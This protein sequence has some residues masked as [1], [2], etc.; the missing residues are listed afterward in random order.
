MD[1]H[2][3]TLHIPMEPKKALEVLNEGCMDVI[4]YGKINGTDFFCTCGVGFDA[5][6]S[7]KFAHAGKRGLLTYLEKTLQESLKYQPETYELKT[8]NGVTKYKSF[9]LI[10][11]GNASQYGNNAYIAP[12]ATLT[13]WIAGCDDSRNL[14][15]FWMCLRS[16][17]SYSIK[18]S[19]R[20]VGS[21]HS[22][23]D[24]CVFVEP[25]RVWYISTVI[26]WKRMLM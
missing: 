24:D 25:L 1:L 15:P 26:L 13:E 2:G 14:S 4:D 18:Q 5:F 17:F 9:F 21:R 12:Q 7:L 23:V 8:E 19:I 11:C 10:A 22:V 16:L 3:T 6:V 20:T